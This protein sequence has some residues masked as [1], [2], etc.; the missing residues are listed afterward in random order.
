[1]TAI[2]LRIEDIEARVC[3]VAAEQLGIQR[4]KVSPSDR[5]IEDLH[6]D[7]M[8]LVELL[9]ELEEAFSVTLP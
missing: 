9:M 6:C 7:S 5:L 2:H 3:D 8:D 1:M 4:A